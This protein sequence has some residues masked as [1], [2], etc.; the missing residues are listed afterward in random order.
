[1]FT[2]IWGFYP[3]KFTLKILGYKV[4]SRTHIILDIALNQFVFVKLIRRIEVGS[5]DSM[6]IVRMR[7]FMMD[8][9]QEL[10]SLSLLYL[11]LLYVVFFGL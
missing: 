7:G 1:M 9:L 4:S 10:I 5:R 3:S 6:I 8:A 11:L 2:Y